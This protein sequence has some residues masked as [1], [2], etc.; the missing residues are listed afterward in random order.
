M[1][2]SRAVLCVKVVLLVGLTAVLSQQSGCGRGKGLVKKEQKAESRLVFDIA[3]GELP[4]TLLGIFKRKPQ[5]AVW[6]EDETGDFLDTVFVT[7]TM[8]QEEFWFSS[9]KE[10]P[11]VLPIWLPLARAARDRET[12]GVPDKNLVADTVTGAT[13][14]AGVFQL[15]WAVPDELF[16]KTV[17]FKVEVN[18]RH[19]ENEAYPDNFGQPS[20]LWRGEIHMG[21]ET[22]L[23]F[24]SIVGHGAPDGAT[25]AILTDMEGLDTELQRFRTVKV[26]Y[27]P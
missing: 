5:F 10:R 11:Y 17:V 3:M 23:S 26:T 25:G 4:R 15:L 12:L 2:P 24:G 19:D 9:L 27:V 20:V 18:A 22:T 8:G 6:V 14:S 7:R 21:R 1:V 13:P 16:E